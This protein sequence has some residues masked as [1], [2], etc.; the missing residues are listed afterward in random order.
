MNAALLQWLAAGLRYQMPVSETGAAHSGMWDGLGSTV[1]YLRTKWTQ[2]CPHICSARCR[3]HIDDSRRCVGALT[4]VLYLSD[5]V[6][7]MG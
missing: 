3:R 4:D 6:F 7:A 5:C 1:G 2:R